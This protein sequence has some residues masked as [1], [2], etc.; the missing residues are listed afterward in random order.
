ML[1]V[2]F[3][4]KCGLRACKKAR[5]STSQSLESFSEAANA[6]V[7][8]VSVALREAWD[9]YGSTV[10]CCRAVQVISMALPT[11]P[12][13]KNMATRIGPHVDVANTSSALF[14]LTSASRFRE[15]AIIE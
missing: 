9:F 14:V 1:Y 15:S 12:H 7:V 8:P 10:L 11:K 4:T 5:C 2:S 6:V 13:R 3:K